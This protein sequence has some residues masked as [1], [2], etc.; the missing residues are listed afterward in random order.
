MSRDYHAD[1]V[2][3]GVKVSRTYETK[4]GDTVYSRGLEKPYNELLETL[5]MVRLRLLTTPAD[6]IVLHRL[7][8]YL[9]INGEPDACEAIMKHA[10]PAMVLDKDDFIYEG[11]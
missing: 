5:S 11:M 1:R 2:K 8:W 10:V 6:R 9:G 4:G 7:A 3:K